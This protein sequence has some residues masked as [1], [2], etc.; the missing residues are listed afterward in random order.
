MTRAVLAS[1]R[2]VAG[3]QL[4]PDAPLMDAGLDSLGAV[5]LR[6]ALQHMGV[7]TSVPGA[8]GILR[9]YDDWPDGKLDVTEFGR[10][11]SHA[12][13]AC[14]RGSAHTVADATLPP[15]V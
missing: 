6:N 13:G 11:V 9:Q 1:A 8:I 3:E 4:R 7:D 15:M 12:P 14:Y 2:K 5:E 10:L